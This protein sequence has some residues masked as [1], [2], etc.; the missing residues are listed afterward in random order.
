[1]S[2]LCPALH[3]KLVE[4][5]ASAGFPKDV[6]SVV[7]NAPE[8]AGEVVEALIAHRAV[9][10]VTFTGSTHVG[11]IIGRLCGENLKPAL[12]ELGG[13]AV[14][15]VQNLV[16]EAE[17]KGAKVVCG[18]NATDT[19]MEATI[20]DHVTPEMRIYGEESFGPSVS[21]VRV[22]GEEEA[23]RIANDT[24]YGLSSAV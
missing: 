19:F 18:G 22:N 17:S 24:D 3:I 21:I 15:R 6:I 4:I 23:I 8:D 1:A 20:V 10:R 13:N 11:K 12:L 9:R 2:E 5:I 14:T 7:T 16:R